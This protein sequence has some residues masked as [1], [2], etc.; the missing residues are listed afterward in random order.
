MTNEI[1][2]FIADVLKIDVASDP[3]ALDRFIANGQWQPQLLLSATSSLLV[4]SHYPHGYL[5]SRYLIQNGQYH[6]ISGLG[7]AIGG[8]M[9]GN[10]HDYQLGL[11][12]LTACAQTMTAEQQSGFYTG[13][14]QSSLFRLVQ[15]GAA[16]NNDQ[17]SLRVLDI[18]KAG[19]IELRDIFDFNATHEFDLAAQLQRGRAS[20][21]L[22]KYAKPTLDR[23]PS[24][25][26]ALV[27]MPELPANWH[28]SDAELRL[29]HAAEQRGWTAIAHERKVPKS[30][31]ELNEELK[32]IIDRCIQND[33]NLVL[34]ADD[35]VAQSAILQP[36]EEMIRTLKVS[37]PG[38]KIVAIY[39]D[40]W[41][42]TP[43]TLIKAV[44]PVDL[45]WALQPANPAWKLPEIADKVL[46][47][48]FPGFNITARTDRR[49]DGRMIFAGTV[50][51]YNWHRLFWLAAARTHGVPLEFKPSPPRDIASSPID[52]VKDY[53]DRL[54]ESGCALSFAMRPD[55][56]R[57]ATGRT[58]EA[59]LL[60]ALLVQE[61]SPDLD[62][63]FVAGEH[64]LQFRTF[65]EL[66]AISRFIA[67]HPEQ[68]EEIRHRGNE[69]ALN[70]YSDQNSFDYLDRKLQDLEDQSS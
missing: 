59:T 12:I 25:R 3:S 42:A 30:M 49:I 50:Q 54:R 28:A 39:Y 41:M 68:A 20:A 19:N 44:R 32:K 48:P 14:L 63:Y 64:Y 22:V 15:I 18:F 57:I 2:E 23:P 53:F 56:S 29:V 10:T 43:D 6:A 16:N 65:S 45:V 7:L 8:C 60:G 1:S 33:I 9:N 34:M 31:D 35:W 70:H 62:Y 27:V 21:C 37:L 13:V 58:F 26:K 17:F 47:M 66:A 46:H 52:H 51:G 36:R 69:F 61:Y 67:A 5:L 11:Q 4:G 55:L 38:I 24:R 40:A